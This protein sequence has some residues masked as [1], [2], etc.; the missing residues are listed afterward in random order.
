MKFTAK[1]INSFGLIY[2]LI[3]AVLVAIEVVKVYRGSITGTIIR[4]WGEMGKPTPE[5]RTFE[6]QKHTYMK[7]GLG[8]LITGFLLQ[9]LAIWI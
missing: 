3:G 4:I 1:I 7:I 5:Y 6:K 9:I 8:Y 2:S